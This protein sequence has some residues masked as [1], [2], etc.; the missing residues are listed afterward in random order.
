MVEGWLVT[1][2]LDRL[3][4]EHRT[5]VQSLYYDGRTIADTALHLAVP[6]GTVKSRAYYAVRALRAAFEEMGVLAG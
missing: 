1:A 3:S 6:Q 5:V 4:V 2:A